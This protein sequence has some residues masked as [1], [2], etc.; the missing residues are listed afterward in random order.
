MQEFSERELGFAKTA[1]EDEQCL[2]AEGPKIGRCE[3]CDF[4]NDVKRQIAEMEKTDN[5]E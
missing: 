1:I 2:C 5:E 3:D 4:R